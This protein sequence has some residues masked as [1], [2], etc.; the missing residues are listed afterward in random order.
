MFNLSTS[1]FL[2]WDWRMLDPNRINL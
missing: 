2:T 1:T